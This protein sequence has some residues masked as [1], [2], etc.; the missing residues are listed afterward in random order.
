[1][2]AP[3]PNGAS[4]VLLL[5]C[6]GPTVVLSPYLCCPGCALNAWACPTPPSLLS[7]RRPSSP[8]QRGKDA[9]EDCWRDRRDVDPS[10]L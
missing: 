1:M 8:Q 2:S 9:G 6:R 3:P 4:P 5:L 10:S 7:S